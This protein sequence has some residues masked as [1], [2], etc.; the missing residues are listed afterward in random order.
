MNKKIETNSNPNSE[1]YDIF[2]NS[3]KSS[4][5]WTTYFEVY[6][7]IFKKYKN[8]QITFVEV[9][10]ANG[11]SLFIWKKYFSKDSRIIGIDLNPSA[12]KLE[13]YGFEIYIGNQTK[14]EFWDIFYSK[15]GKLDILLDDGG[16]KNL[17]QVSTVHYSLP[18]VKDDGKIVIEDTHTSFIK[19]EFGN[20]SKYS[21]INF[22]N[23]IISSIHERCGV[24][25]KKL[26]IYSKKIFYIDFFESIVVFNINEAKCKISKSVTNNAKNE[27]AI[28]YRNNEYFDK[29]K[30]IINK[31][32]V[33]LNKNKLFKKI[34]RKILYKNFIFQFYENI[35]LKKIFDQLKK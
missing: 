24:F 31:K 21:F 22:C 2:I 7:K 19:K 23:L 25:E 13:K 3:E 30:E 17:Q 27:W 1:I 20:P 33:Y 29:T 28:D 18:H 8:K 5:K 26:N 16:H 11:G 4:T 35:K 10:V 15:V 32:F 9:G 6:D 14:K 12:K 34:I